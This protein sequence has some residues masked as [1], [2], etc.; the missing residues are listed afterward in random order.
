MAAGSTTSYGFVLGQGGLD[1][2]EV[3]GVDDRGAHGVQDDE[4]AV[5]ADHGPLVGRV[6]GEGVE[7]GRPEVAG[8]VVEGELEAAMP[9]DISGSVTSPK[10]PSIAP[11]AVEAASRRAGLPTRATSTPGGRARRRWTSRVHRSR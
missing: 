11:A 9:F 5:G 6:P 7:P 2:G 1:D 10:H 8:L 3:G 4:G